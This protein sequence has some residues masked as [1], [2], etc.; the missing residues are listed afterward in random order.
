MNAF[1]LFDKLEL[2]KKFSGLESRINVLDS[3]RVAL[4]SNAI[5]KWTQ[6]D[7]HFHIVMLL[8]AGAF[9]VSSNTMDEWNLE[10]GLQASGIPH[11]IREINF[12]CADSLVRF[13]VSPPFGLGGVSTN[14]LIKTV[15]PYDCYEA[16][17]ALV[18]DALI[19]NPESKKNL[20]PGGTF[21]I[22]LSINPPPK[23]RFLKYLDES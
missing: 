22:R 18:E 9:R 12:R 16:I 17:D 20:R 6:F 14:D 11:P 15:F 10:L 3:Q 13:L 8:R 1:N 23:P 5:R 19:L 7:Q 21:T 2:E 4:S